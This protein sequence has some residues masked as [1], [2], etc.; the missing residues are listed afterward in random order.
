MWEFVYV[1]VPLCTWYPDVFMIQELKTVFRVHIFIWVLYVLF[2]HVYRVRF[3][4]R[5]QISADN[6]YAIVWF[7]FGIGLPIFLPWV[8]LHHTSTY[9]QTVHSAFNKTQ[10]ANPLSPIP[11]S[12]HCQAQGSLIGWQV[13]WSNRC[14]DCVLHLSENCSFVLLFWFSTQGV[15]YNP[16][17]FP[18]PL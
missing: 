18:W 10:T 12:A 15:K 6:K 9:R 3:A 16:V 11:F 14:C 8:F 4:C 17:T 2:L 13:I 1:T 7:I 5:L